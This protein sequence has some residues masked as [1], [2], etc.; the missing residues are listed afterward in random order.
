MHKFCL[1]DEMLKKYFGNT[2]FVTWVKP[3][4]GYFMNLEFQNGMASKIY[5]I[6]KSHGV[7][8][9]PAGSTFPYGKDPNDKYIRLAPTY[10][11]YEE[12]KKAMV[13]LCYSIKEAYGIL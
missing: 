2:D 5:E 10:P 8:I 12:L 6:C 1:I 3:K 13:V 9:T 4:G 7:K 11:S